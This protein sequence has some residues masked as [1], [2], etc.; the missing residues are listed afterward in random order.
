MM[1][2]ELWIDGGT[3]NTRFTLT[4]GEKVLERSSKPVGAANATAD[5]NPALREAVAGEVQR[6]QRAHR[7]S[8][9][10]IV[11]A[12]MI[13]SSSGLCEVKH[14]ASPAGLQELGAAVRTAF[15]PDISSAPMLCIPG[16]RC[17]FA[18]E[19]DMMRGEETEIMGMSNLHE[20][21]RHLYV[22]F[23]SHNKLIEV[24]NGQIL[25][26]ITTDTGELMAAVT[27]HT[28]LAG[29]LGKP[30]EITLERESLLCGF[31]SAEKNGLSRAL[32]ETRLLQTLEGKTRNAAYSYLFGALC[33][34]D[35]KAFAPE[36][37]AE[38]DDV[39]LYGREIWETAFLWCAEEKM[40]SCRFR[41][42]GYEESQWLS[43][44][45]M[46]RIMDV[47]D[48]YHEAHR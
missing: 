23:G 22:H 21:G 5:G 13:T 41:C 31:A 48:R 30:I 9:E 37:I 16:I 2:Y 18:G 35:L 43:L 32:F 14:I 12:G 47:Y 26:S 4:D 46:R 7:L 39:V 28:V 40:S 36:N 44:R 42:I 1:R 10:R 27:G 20:K 6:L 34:Q 15:L 11:L 17:E 3:T 25:H 8:V 45:G 38:A 19:K 33:Q 29:T 24:R